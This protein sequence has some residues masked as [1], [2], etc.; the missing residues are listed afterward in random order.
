[1]VVG[2]AYNGSGVGTALVAAVEHQ[3]R[4]DGV[5]LFSVKTLADTHQDQGYAPTRHFYKTCGFFPLEV[6]DL[7]GED[8]PCLIMVKP[9]Y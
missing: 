2:R 6:I 9:L 5:R 7:W 1:M 8:N 4:V 3:L